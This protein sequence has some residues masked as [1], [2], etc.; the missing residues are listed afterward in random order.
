MCF[1]SLF[2]CCPSILACFLLPHS[3]LFYFLPVAVKEGPAREIGARGKKRTG[4]FNW[5]A[6]GERDG[7][8]WEGVRRVEAAR[9]Q[10]AP[11]TLNINTFS[12][13]CPLND[14]DWLGCLLVGL[15][16]HT[17]THV[18]AQLHTLP[19]T[20]LSYPWKWKVPRRRHSGV[21]GE[22]S[23]FSTT[24]LKRE[25]KTSQNSLNLLFALLTVGTI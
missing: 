23:R 20:K 21:I 1:F 4:C 16:T 7:V 13:L 22:P 14:I 25:K 11:E 2:F 3:T 12:H 10:G 6:W 17:Y 9:I 18:H 15:G 5:S 19:L 24:W 8:K